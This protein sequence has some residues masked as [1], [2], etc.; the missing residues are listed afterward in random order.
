V[1][2]I[3]L[4]A[5][6]NYIL[7]PLMSQ[8]SSPFD[9]EIDLLDLFVTVWNNKWVILLAMIGATILGMLYSMTLPSSYSGS[10]FIRAA[11]PSAFTRYAFLSE[12]I[13]SLSINYKI[14]DKFVFNAL[15]SEFN[16]FEEV[17]QTLRV[18]E[19]VVQK[20][21]EMEESEQEG[22]I[23]S[24]AKQFKIVPPQKDETQTELQFTWGDVDAG[25]RIFET[26]LQLVLTNVHATLSADIDQYA[27]GAQRRL[28]IKIENANLKKDVIKEGIQLA[29]KQRQLFLT[30][31]A[32]IAREL[33]VAGYFL[34]VNEQS[35]TPGNNVLLSV[36]SSSLPFYMRGY[37]AIEKEMALIQARSPED[38]LA[39]SKEYAAAQQEI[40]V[41]EN[42]SSFS[43]LMV[44][45]QM[46]DTDDPMR[47]VLFDLNLAEVTSN[48][49]TN[50]ILA[51]ALVLGGMLGI[52]FVLIR[53]GVRKR[54]LTG[55]A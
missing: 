46:I 4:H 24:R 55:E 1:Y 25:K 50:L 2:R 40:Y 31:Q 20:L 33:G 27:K 52:I 49:K 23:I 13:E 5:F 32:I 48:K 51:L 3:A 44:A 34:G 45:R 39:L 29:D 36:Q 41:L 19:F 18:D 14:D 43:H 22:F 53:S 8:N 6:R 11:Q 7:G 16:D 21:S 15:I 12:A 35:I 28:A 54:N 30:E 9:D 38:R 47:W 37:T 26:A 17:I 10:T 42:D